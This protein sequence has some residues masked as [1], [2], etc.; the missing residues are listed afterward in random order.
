MEEVSLQWEYVVEKKVWLFQRPEQPELYMSENCNTTV[1]VDVKTVRLDP[2][3]ATYFFTGQCLWAEVYL[4]EICERKD[5]PCTT[6][7]TSQLS[8]WIASESGN[9]QKLLVWLILYNIVYHMQYDKVKHM[10]VIEL[11]LWGI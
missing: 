2:Q 3:A 11:N 9:L 7:F 5:T 6:A 8:L 1:S 4:Q 10:W